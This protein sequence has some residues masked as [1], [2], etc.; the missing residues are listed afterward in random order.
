MV[1][2][3]IWEQFESLIMVCTVNKDPRDTFEYASMKKEK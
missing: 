3:G 1:A 2:R